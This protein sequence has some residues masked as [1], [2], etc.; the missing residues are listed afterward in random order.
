M[1]YCNLTL[2]NLFANIYFVKQTERIKQTKTSIGQALYSL[3]LKMPYE[4]ITISDICKEAKISRVSF[5]HYFDKK[6]DVLIQFC[7]ERFAEFF[8]DFS[9]V[10][11]MTFEDLIEE[12]F[13]FIKNHSHEMALL[14][15]A[16]KEDILLKQFQS[17]AKYIIYHSST[18]NLFSNHQEPHFSTFL[19]GGIIQVLLAWIDEGMITPVEEIKKEILSFLEK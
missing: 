7:D 9:K 12:M 14:R 19:T 8:E 16:N 3:I 4:E 6:D 5:Y 17:Y 15:Y 13:T 10:E 1:R 11:K 18:S 2:V